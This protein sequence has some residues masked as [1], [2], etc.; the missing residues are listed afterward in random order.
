VKLIFIT[1]GEKDVMT[2]A[3]MGF[4]AISLNSETASLDKNI[5]DE[6]NRFDKIIILYDNDQTG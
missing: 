4:N 2:L 5:A 1:G 6:L 3:A